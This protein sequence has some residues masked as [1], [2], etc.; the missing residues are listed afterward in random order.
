MFGLVHNK[1]KIKSVIIIIIFFFLGG[2]GRGGRTIRIHT[3][4]HTIVIVIA[5]I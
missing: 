3:Q 2:G 5:Y 4:W 1:K